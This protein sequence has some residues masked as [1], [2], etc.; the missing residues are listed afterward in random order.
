MTVITS[1]SA[2][3][4]DPDLPAPTTYTYRIS[5]PDAGAYESEQPSEVPATTTAQD[6]AVSQAII[7]DHTCTDLSKIPDY[8]IEKA[9]ELAFHYAHTSHGG[10]IRSGIEKLEQVSPPDSKYN[11]RITDAGCTPPTSLPGGPGE[12]RIYDGNPPETYI[13]PED[14]WSEPEGVTRTKAVADTGLFNYS[15][16]SWCGQQSSNPTTTVQLYLDTMAGFETQYPDMR[17]ILMTGHTD[18]GGTDLVRN[19]GM[20]RQYARDNGMVLFDF[21]D[22]E[23]YDPGGGGPYANNGEGN[24]TWCVDWCNN[25]PG[26]CT[27]LPSSCNH[28]QDHPEDRLFCKLKG[29]AFWWMMARLAGWDGGVVREGEAQKTPS[30]VTPVNGQTV[31]YTIVVRGI[32]TTVQLTDR[33]PTGLSYLTNTFTATVGTVDDGNAPTLSWSGTLSPTPAVTVTYAVTVNHITSGTAALP[34]VISNTAT[35]VAP[36]YETIT[37]TATI[38]ANGYSAYLPLMMRSN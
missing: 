20:V 7:I 38:I 3:P 30:T 6:S 23:T 10:Q 34:R 5:G 35:I 25:H 29:Q 12:L 31:T 1:V 11:I 32:T 37:A 8:W 36:G 21:A 15:M 18:G 17:F 16:W 2:T 9:K 27:D 24:C 26:D 22:I 19:N 33:V 28:S 4:P 14:Y 13:T